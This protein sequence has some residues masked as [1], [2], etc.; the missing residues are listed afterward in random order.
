MSEPYTFAHHATRC[1]EAAHSRVVL[2]QFLKVKLRG[3]VHCARI[4]HAWTTPD[5]LDL[6]TVELLGPGAGQLSI[7]YKQT[8][9]CSGVDG[10]CH[11][12]NEQTHGAAGAEMPQASAPAAQGVLA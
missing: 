12:A 3:V 7:P 4:K 5:G 2:I 8:R 10:R 11:C 6:W 9:Q 1:M